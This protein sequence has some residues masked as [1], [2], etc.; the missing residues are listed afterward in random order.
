MEVLTDPQGMADIF[1]GLQI[2]GRQVYKT[3]LVKRL[4]CLQYQLL[5]L[6]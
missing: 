2:V 1:E 4:K 6:P 3:P 5:V